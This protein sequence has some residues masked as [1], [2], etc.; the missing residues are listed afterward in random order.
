MS[1]QEL[2]DQIVKHYKAFAASQI[3]VI[4][5]YLDGND[6][7]T[8]VYG[9]KEAAQELVNGLDDA[10]TYLIYPDRFELIHSKD[11]KWCNNK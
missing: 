10:G 4:E 2:L 7:T 3:E 5:R 9:A 11:C 6:G 1:E 8:N